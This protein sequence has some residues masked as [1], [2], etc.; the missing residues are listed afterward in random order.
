M[1]LYCIA[2]AG[3]PFHMM[4]EVSW[5]PKRRQAWASSYPILSDKKGRRGGPSKEKYY[6]TL[7]NIVNLTP[8]NLSW[9]RLV[10]ALCCFMNGP[11]NGGISFTLGLSRNKKIMVTWLT[12]ICIQLG[13]PLRKKFLYKTLARILRGSEVCFVLFHDRIWQ[14]VISCTVFLVIC[15][16]TYH[17]EFQLY[18]AS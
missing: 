9:P 7:I 8:D 11:D 6:S 3:L 2:G 16:Q 10:S 17:G 15:V 5:D 4:R 18:P 12:S 13:K 14:G 1:Y